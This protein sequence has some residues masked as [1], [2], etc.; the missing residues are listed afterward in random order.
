M[1]FLE[2]K[3]DGTCVVLLKGRLDAASAE[4]AQTRL[5]EI[6]EREKNIRMDLKDLEFIS[7]SGLRV[8]LL[9]SKKVKKMEGSFILSNLNEEVKE[10]FNIT[11][12]SGFLQLE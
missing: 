4:M 3:R 2:E 7:S 5:M 6:T 10:I 12:F 11:G 1:E 9:V 8:I